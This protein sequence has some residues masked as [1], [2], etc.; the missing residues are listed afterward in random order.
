MSLLR[1]VTFNSSSCRVLTGAPPLPGSI[2]CTNKYGLSIWIVATT[3]RRQLRELKSVRTRD[4]GSGQSTA[5]AN[6]HGSNPSNG[7][8]LGE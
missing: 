6:S 7:T 3:S 8:A 5:R 2:S 1:C 4:S